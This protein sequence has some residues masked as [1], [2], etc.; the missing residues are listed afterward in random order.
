MILQASKIFSRATDTDF[1][2]FHNSDLL[3]SKCWML[4]KSEVI[5][6]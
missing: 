4:N 1:L 6:K 3:D 2:K 5:E